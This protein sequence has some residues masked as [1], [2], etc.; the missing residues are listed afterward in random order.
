MR[1]LLPDT[2]VEGVYYLTLEHI[3]S[4]EKPGAEKVF[5]RRITDNEFN[6]LIWIALDGWVQNR[7][8]WANRV[9]NLRRWCEALNVSFANIGKTILWLSS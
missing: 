4:R 9:D 2:S 6:H 8:R 7:M 1:K 5:E 3:L